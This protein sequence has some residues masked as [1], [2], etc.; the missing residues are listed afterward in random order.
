MGGGDEGCLSVQSSIGATDMM[1]RRR[2]AWE[3]MAM[4]MEGRMGRC[5]R[6]DFDGGGQTGG[7]GRDRGGQIK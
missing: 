5:A 2:S 6:Q 4:R 7:G 1:W 3:L